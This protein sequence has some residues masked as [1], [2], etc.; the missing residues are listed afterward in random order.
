MR[1]GN[2]RNITEE[3]VHSAG[4]DNPA[5]TGLTSNYTITVELPKRT[6]SWEG[7]LDFRI[8]AGNFHYDYTRRLPKRGKLLREKNWRETVARDPQ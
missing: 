7:I 8:D 5:A 3:I 1:T 2:R 6:L 4:D